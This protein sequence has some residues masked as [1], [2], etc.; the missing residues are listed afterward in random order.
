MIDSISRKTFLKTTSFLVHKFMGSDRSKPNS[1][2]EALKDEKQRVEEHGVITVSSL[3][4]AVGDLRSRVSALEVNVQS[5]FCVHMTN[6][7]F[8]QQKNDRSKF[9]SC[10]EAAVVEVSHDDSSP[11]SVKLNKADATHLVSGFVHESK[12][13]LFPNQQPYYNIPAIV[14]HFVLT[15]FYEEMDSF[16]ACGDTMTISSGRKGKDNILTMLSGSGWNTGFGS[17]PIAVSSTSTS[18][19][20]WTMKCQSDCTMYGISEFEPKTFNTFCFGGSG[21]TWKC[22]GLS[23]HGCKRGH[24]DNPFKDSYVAK[25]AFPRGYH[26]GDELKLNDCVGG[27]AVEPG[28]V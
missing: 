18:V 13:Q 14:I 9:N 21:R 16:S 23:E 27:D 1:C 8:E 15:Y 17:V 5:L 22:Y 4:K 11:G 20:E 24:K 7:S 10:S 12:L 6:I 2:P 3:E 19:Y 26:S 25:K 28:R